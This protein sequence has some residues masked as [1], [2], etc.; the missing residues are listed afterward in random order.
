VEQ[1][2]GRKKNRSA[3]ALRAEE[4]GGPLIPTWPKGRESRTDRSEEGKAE[5]KGGANVHTGQ[6]GGRKG[7]VWERYLAKGLASKR[8]LC[9]Q[10]N[11]PRE[12]RTVVP[13]IQKMEYGESSGPK[14]RMAIT[15][16]CEGKRRK[17][18]P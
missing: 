2:K 16:K 5:K 3:Y 14:P 17:V 1:N 9:S 11:D 6:G 4:T 8:T 15:R 13:R 10:W 18:Q 7:L 12:G